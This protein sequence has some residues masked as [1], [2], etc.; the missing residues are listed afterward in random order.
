[1][2][3]T[4]QQM[5]KETH[6]RH[7]EVFNGGDI[8]TLPQIIE[9][10]LDILN[11]APNDPNVLFFIGTAHMQLGYNGMAIALIE[12]ARALVKE[13]GKG[14]QPEFLCN[15]G[16]AWKAEHDNEK[17]EEMWL[18]ALELKECDEYYNNLATLYINEGNPGPG[19]LMANK[20]IELNPNNKKAHWNRSLL[21]LEAGLFEQGWVDF[22]YGL[23]TGDRPLRAFSKNPDDIP[24]YAGQHLDN[25]Q[26]I[27]VYGEQGLGDEI[28]FMSALPDLIETGANVIYECHDRLEDVIR[29]TFPEIEV[30]PT[31]KKNTIDWALNKH[32]DYRCAI[33]SLFRWFRKDNVYPQKPY[34]IPDP[35]LVQDY[36]NL[37]ATLGKGPYVGFGYAGGAKRTHAKYRSSQLTPLLPIMEQ[38]CTFL[39]VQYTP[40]AKDKFDR[41]HANTGIKVHHFGDV[42]ESHVVDE[43]GK[44][45]P[46]RGMNYDHSL[47]L[48]YALDLVIVPNTTAVH[49]CGA[50]G[51]EV[52]S[53]TP[54]ACAWRYRNGGEDH[55]LWYGDHV[56]LY[57]ENGDRSQAIQ[58]MADDLE[59]F[60][61]VYR[62]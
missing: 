57:R 43:D 6:E 55:M 62:G 61:E 11:Y 52:W 15:L 9:E 12:Y 34:L 5:L 50:L 37:L 35:D 47:A 3:K 8:R 38:D 56:K 44:R 13:Q 42:I 4:L 59:K 40:D 7:T 54:D 22:D 41:H 30:H 45:V 17:A 24:I 49:A 18:K 19:I 32:I 20:A 28:M 1:M 46:S 53:L 51:K 21:N 31:R 39:S 23:H 60:I 48:F 14:E 29:R 33:G 58:R 27:V 2:A 10:Y 36:K 25:T 16:S 26:T